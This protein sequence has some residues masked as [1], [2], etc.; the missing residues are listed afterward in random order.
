MANVH[1]CIQPDRI[2]RIDETASEA[3]AE[4]YVGT[5]GRPSITVRM[6]RVEMIARCL[7]YFGS[8]LALAAIIAAFT[9]LFKSALAREAAPRTQTAAVPPQYEPASKN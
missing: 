8:T 6:D 2:K 1:E 9:F 4:L 3:Y 5:K 7:T